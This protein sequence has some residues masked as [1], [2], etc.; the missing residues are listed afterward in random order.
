MEQEV[1]GIRRLIETGEMPIG[2]VSE[3]ARKDQNIRRG[4]LHS[5]HIWWATLPLGAS[6]AVLMDTLLPDPANEHC[7]ESFCQAAR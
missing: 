2:H 7:P 3:H 6:R 4:H 1:K 5:M